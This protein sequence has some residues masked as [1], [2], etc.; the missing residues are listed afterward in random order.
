MEEKEQQQ[1]QELYAREERCARAI[2]TLS[3][4]V[5][6]RLAVEAVLLLGLFWGQKPD[7]FRIGIGIFVTLIN[8]GS[9]VPL[10]R[11]LRRQTLLWRELVAQEEE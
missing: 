6:L 9:T 10:F 5:V 8:L 4:S 7:G 3:R 1:S 11:E 2:K